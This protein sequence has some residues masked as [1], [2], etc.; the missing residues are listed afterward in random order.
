MAEYVK[1]ERCQLSRTVVNS[2]LR[3]KQLIEFVDNRCSI[4]KQYKLTR[5]AERKQ[6]PNSYEK[7]V[8]QLQRFEL[9][10][11]TGIAYRGDY[12]EPNIIFSEGFK[13]RVENQELQNYIDV[14]HE[15]TMN[16]PIVSVSR[17][18]EIAIGFGN[19]GGFLYILDLDGLEG[20]DIV[21]S[22]C[23]EIAMKEVPN[24]H[25]R[26]AMGPLNTSCAS[27]LAT[28]ALGVI[29]VG[30]YWVYLRCTQQKCTLEDVDLF[31]NANYMGK[32][33]N[34]DEE[35]LRLIEKFKLKKREEAV[36]AKEKED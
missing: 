13:P 6:L 34:S 10:R 35:G 1:E 9:Q 5:I 16:Y 12:R 31:I 19:G 33:K 22:E 14:F 11:Q 23:E 30:I 24:T 20:Y 26:M 28:I 17:N 15:I 27:L 25:I 36:G 32:E 3:N 21:G 2:K 18:H 29:S 8:R 4:D 7:N